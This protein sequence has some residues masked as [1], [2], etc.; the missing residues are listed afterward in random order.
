ME[1]VIWSKERCAAA[2][3]SQ[4]WAAGGLTLMVVPERVTDTEGEVVLRCSAI[5][6]VAS[7]VAFT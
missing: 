4:E 7:A 3:R 6:R 5:T 1:S 2:C